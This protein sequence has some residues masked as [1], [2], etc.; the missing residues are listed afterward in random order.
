M[1]YT[2]QLIAAIAGLAPFLSH[3]IYWKELEHTFQ[4][5]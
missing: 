2:K 3:P 5:I 4:M 1:I